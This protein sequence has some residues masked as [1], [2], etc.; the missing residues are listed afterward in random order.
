M[1]I[2]EV[3]K[4]LRES[5]CTWMHDRLDLEWRRAIWWHRFHVVTSCVT[6][7]LA[8]CVCVASAIGEGVHEPVFFMV[9]ST[10]FFAHGFMVPNHV[11]WRRR[12]H[13]FDEWRRK[14]RVEHDVARAYISEL[15]DTLADAAPDAARDLVK[16][17]R[18]RLAELWKTNP[19]RDR[20]G[21]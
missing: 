12:E 8:I 1:N 20:D 7:L 3:E 15:A 10:A 21:R 13:D 11:E 5:P 2:N 9:V 16:R 18:A 19:I 14:A 6:A 4:E 17:Q